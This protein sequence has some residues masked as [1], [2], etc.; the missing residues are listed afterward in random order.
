MKEIIPSF[1]I[2]PTKGLVSLNLREIWEYRD[3]LSI[4]IWRDIKVRYKQTAIG[5]AWV[6]IQPLL[7]MAIFTLFFG[8]LAKIPSEG[9]PYPIFAYA[10]LLPW[11]FFSKALTEASTSLVVNE[12]VI[13]KVYF[14]RLLVPMAVVLAGLID[15]AIAFTILVGMMIYYGIAPSWGIIAAPLFLFLALITA[16][17][18][19]FW[20]SALDV[21]YRDVRY[22]LPFLTQL[23]LFASP[24]VYPSNL[25]PEAWRSL[26]GLN[27]MVGVVEGFRWAL[28]GSSLLPELRMLLVSI[29]AVVV[30]FISGLFY[31][32]RMERTMADR[33]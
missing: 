22:T 16:L 3:L 13:T 27:P 17:G 28:L 18:V 15:F 4:L 5:I 19:S 20:L 31:F 11:Q 8:K 21:E 26:Y 32:R 12:R 10:A 14:P 33:I 23:W 24:V 30:L 2:R 6:V 1:T 29:G 7:A 9:I 25:V